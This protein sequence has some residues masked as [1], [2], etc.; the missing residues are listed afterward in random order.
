[1]KFKIENEKYFEITFFLL[2][3]AKKVAIEQKLE[4]RQKIA[5]MFG[6]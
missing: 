3:K 5:K 4:K 1:M 2:K 6:E